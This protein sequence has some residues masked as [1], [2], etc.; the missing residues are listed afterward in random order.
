MMT[1]S[2]R[3]RQVWSHRLSPL[4]VQTAPGAMPV[5]VCD[6]VPAGARRGSENPGKGRAVTAVHMHHD[7]PCMARRPPPVIVLVTTS[8]PETSACTCR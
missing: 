5:Y 6:V 7:R 2:R 4:T 1:T 8:E 3:H